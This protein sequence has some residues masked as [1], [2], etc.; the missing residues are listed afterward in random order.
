MSRWTTYCDW[1]KFV[2]YCHGGHPLPSHVEPVKFRQEPIQLPLYKAEQIDAVGEFYQTQLAISRDVNLAPGRRFRYS[3]FCKEI[4]TAYRTLYAGEPCKANVDCLITPLNHINEALERMSKLRDYDNCHPISRT[5]WF[6]DTNDI[7][8]QRSWL[9]FKLDSIRPCLLLLV[10]IFRLML[11][12][13]REFWE[14][15][16]G[17]LRRKDWHEQFIHDSKESQDSTLQEQPKMSDVLWHDSRNQTI[18]RSHSGGAPTKR[19]RHTKHL[20]SPTRSTNSHW[21]VRRGAE[22]I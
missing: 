1:V 7:P 19:D 10:H 3:G 17:S 20:P 22:L 8:V 13:H 18:A 11:P 14:E 2:L 16:E 6:H 15:L 5:E 21:T 4:L 12:D 9:R